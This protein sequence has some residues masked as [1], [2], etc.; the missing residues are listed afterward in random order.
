M[1]SSSRR[2]RCLPSSGSLYGGGFAPVV[3]GGGGGGGVLSS[4]RSMLL[5]Q[6]RRRDGLGDGEDYGQRGNSVE[7]AAGICEFV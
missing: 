7:E 3:G 5:P 4:V 6:R 2:N 1:N